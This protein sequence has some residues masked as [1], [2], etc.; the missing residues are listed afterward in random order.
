MPIFANNVRE[1]SR[2]ALTAAAGAIMIAETKKAAHLGGLRGFGQVTEW[3]G[4]RACN[5]WYVG[6][7]P[8]LAFSHAQVA[9]LVAAMVFK[10]MVPPDVRVRIPSC[11]LPNHTDK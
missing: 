9:K 7:N 10:T 1:I 8:T 2:T 5:S 6:S 11:A 3:S 4:T